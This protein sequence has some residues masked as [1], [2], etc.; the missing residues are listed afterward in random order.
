MMMFSLLPSSLVQA[1]SPSL[2][3]RGLG[4]W[5]LLLWGCL[6]LISGLARADESSRLPVPLDISRGFQ[7]ADLGGHLALLRDPSGS[8]NLEE[9]ARRFQTGEFQSLPGGVAAGFAE[10]VLWLGFRLDWSDSDREATTIL[11][12]FPAVIDDLRVYSPLPGGGWHE[13]VSGDMHPLSV[14]EVPGRNLAF[15]LSAPARDREVPV[16]YLVRV[17]TDGSASMVLNL[18]SREAYNHHLQNNGIVLGALMGAIF[19]LVC[20]SLLWLFW[21]GEAL[22]LVHALYGLTILLG[23][24]SL[25]GLHTLV[26]HPD[27]PELSPYTCGLPVFLSVALA[28][29]FVRR[30]LMFSAFYPRLNRWWKW[31]TVFSILAIASIPLGIYP[32]TA[33]VVIVLSGVMTLGGWWVSLLEARRGGAIAR[34]F[35]FAFCLS[36]LGVAAAIGRILGILPTSLLSFAIGEVATG[37]QVLLLTAGMAWRVRFLQEQRLTW[38][39]TSLELSR[40]ME[41]MLE[42]RV[43]E[44]T[45]RLQQEVAVREATERELRQREAELREALVARKAEA[46]RQRRFNALI[47]HEFRT[48]LAVIDSAAQLLG[49]TGEGLDSGQQT[50]LARIRAQVRHMVMI[51]DNWLTEDQLDQEVI[52]PQAEAVALAPLLQEFATLGGRGEHPLSWSAAAPPVWADPTILRVMLANLIDNACKYS[53]SGSPVELRAELSSLPGF[54][55][56]AVLD[57]GCG[58]P[59]ALRERIFLPYERHLGDVGKRVGGIGLG[60]AIV[61]RLAHLQGGEVLMA[62]RPGGGSCFY[63]RLPRALSSGGLPA[64]ASPGAGTPDHPPCHEMA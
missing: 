30:V 5:F 13:S 28:S 61:R 41:R 51:F 52:R 54:V 11:Q 40:K 31:L 59:E 37:F 18:F 42:S 26:L 47:S 49:R 33:Q 62:A 34:V 1:R 55:H 38:H 60:L 58:V 48:P 25:E 22:Y 7:D 39:E 10:G 15:G 57:R 64:S 32:F 46:D 12:V 20:V 36:T 2:G 4:G 21:W 17:R 19:T 24:A 45:A 35:F 43:L 27:R 53:P 9:A 6:C 56:L 50:R 8:L 14:R 3:T 23:F 16:T 44:R 29:E 63:L